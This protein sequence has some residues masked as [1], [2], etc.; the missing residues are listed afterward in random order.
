MSSLTEGA[1]DTPKAAA[2]VLGQRLLDDVVLPAGS[3]RLTTPEPAALGEFVPQPGVGNLLF[4]HRLF[5]VNESPYDLWHFLQAHV[6]RGF[7]SAGGA[8]GT[9]GGLQMFGVEDD[10]SVVPPNIS[11]A[12]LQLRIVGDAAGAGVVRVDS[13]I[14]WT[15]PR[16]A[17]EFVSRRDRVMILSTIHIFEPGEPIGKHLVVTDAHLVGPIVTAFNSAR[18]QAP[19]D[20][21]ECGPEGVREFAYRIA[22]ATSSQATPDVVATPQCYEVSVTV[23]RRAAPFLQNLSEQA[24]NDIADDLGI[25]EPY[26]LVGR[27]RR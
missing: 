8:S 20:G 1:T 25:A 15:A 5:T 7:R 18:V 27:Q 11:V 4:A 26:P 22:F 16:P 21:R 10:L 13:E 12:E 17:D 14:A 6:P 19:L 2:V 23:N 9:I 24:W 3:R